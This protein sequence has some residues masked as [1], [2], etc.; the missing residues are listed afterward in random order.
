M[1]IV[2]LCGGLK[3]S[4]IVEPEEEATGF[5]ILPLSADKMKEVVYK[6]CQTCLQQPEVFQ[7]MQMRGMTTDF[8]W[9]PRIDEYMMN[10]DWCLNDP[11]FVR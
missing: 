7:A 5:G 10:F 9:C 6:A 3:D 4:V 8:S 2:T 1:P 11:P